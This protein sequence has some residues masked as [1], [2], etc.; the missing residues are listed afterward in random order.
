ME[1]V[2]EAPLQLN[3]YP[4]KMKDMHR[5][6]DNLEKE[7]KSRKHQ[8]VE[9]GDM[10]AYKT[11]KQISELVKLQKQL[12]DKDVVYQIPFSLN[13][14][15]KLVNVYFNRKVQETG[16]S[17]D[18]T[19]VTILYETKSLGKLKTELEVTGKKVHFTIYAN[20]L[21][22][23]EKLRKHEHSLKNF[24]GQLGYQIEESSIK[25]QQNDENHVSDVKYKTLNMSQFEQ[26]G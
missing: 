10:P 18:T 20:N 13:G 12:T 23:A 2:K 6:I 16:K 21:E 7:A 4:V 24:I 11:Y 26:I 8:A 17:R 5:A 25:T 15:V 14:E 1:L 9:S 19:H 3:E 22:A